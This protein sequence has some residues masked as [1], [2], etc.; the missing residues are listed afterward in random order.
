M[1]RVILRRTWFAPTEHVKVDRLRTMAGRRY[2]R[3]EHD[4]PEEFM[5]FLPS[6]AQV[7]DAETPAAPEVEVEDDDEEETLAD[8]DEER[9]AAEAMP[10]PD[11]IEAK[12]AAFEAELE[13]E[14]KPKKRG[15]PR[16][17]S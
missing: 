14:E 12:R 5:E 11:E 16:K 3:G 4:I 8:Y 2:R 17:G 1:P 15:R 6:D 13:A 7:L 10:E 9:A